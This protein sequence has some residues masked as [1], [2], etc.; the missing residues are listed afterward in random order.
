M[1]A[2]DFV[3]EN[4]AILLDWYLGERGESGEGSLKTQRVIVQSIGQ[5]VF[6]AAWSGTFVSLVVE[7]LELFE[8]DGYY[9]IN[10]NGFTWISNIVLSPNDSIHAKFYS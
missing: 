2:I 9:T 8:S 6:N 1:E 5:T 7:G 10:G 3:P 4:E